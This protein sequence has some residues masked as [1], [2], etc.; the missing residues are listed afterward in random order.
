MKIHH[1]IL[2]LGACLPAIAPAQLPDEAL[3]CFKWFSTLGYPDVKD[4]K[5]AEIWTGSWSSGGGQDT[6]KA[7]TVMGF[8]TKETASEFTVSRLDLIPETLSKSMQETPAHESVKF[9]ERPFSKMIDQHLEAL[10]HP[11][12]DAFPRFRATLGQRAEV[13]ILSYVCWQ[14]G[15]LDLAAQLYEE[16]RRLPFRDYRIKN[17][18]VTMQESLEIML[19]HTAMWDAVLRCGGGRLG[20]DDWAGSGKLEPRT[21]LLEAF[22]RIARL[23]PRSFEAAEVGQYAAMLERM[24]KEDQ[25]HPVLTQEQIDQLPLEKRIAEL[26]WMLRDQNGHQWGQPGWCDVFSTKK[27]RGSKSPA[28]QL[29]DIGYPAAHAL[30]E[31]LTDERFSRSVGFHRDFHFSHTVLTIG[32]CAQ[33][34]LNHLTGQN[35]YSPASTSGY[36]SNEEKML[37]VQKAA[38]K[39]LEEYQKKGKKQML[40][41]SITAGKTSPNALVQQL[42]AEDPE[43]VEDAVLRGA[44]AA[45]DAWLLRQFIKEL[46]SLKRPAATQ[47]LL[48]IM[49]KNARLEVRLEAAG[50]LMNQKHPEALPAMVHEW[51]TLQTAEH[52]NHDDGFET[53]VEMH[54]A[55]GDVQAMRQIVG[56]WDRLRAGE[57]LNIAQKM[58]EW[59]KEGIELHPFSSVKARPLTQEAKDTG[60]G[61]LVHA[62]EDRETLDGMTGGLG[63][64]CFSS[65]RIC[66]FALWA[67]HEIDA[68]KFAFTPVAGRR[69]RDAERIAAANV[70]GQQFR[71][72]LLPLPPPP[73]A[74]LPE[75]DALKIVSVQIEP[76]KGFEGTSL[77][78]RALELRD[79]TFGPRTISSLLLS[80]ANEPTS[81]MSGLRVEALRE[82]DLT[83]VEIHLRVEPGDY[84]QKENEGWNTMHNGQIGNRNLSSSGGSRS[85]STA[86]N[87]DVW[88]SFEDEIAEGLKSPP[89]TGFILVAS[90]KAS[91]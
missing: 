4:A 85:R 88:E 75:K 44:E 83:G 11:P 68:K 67:L 22:R 81:G 62:L 7:S 72:P 69:Q 35:F 33:Q 12:K 1:L 86:G 45:S 46:G 52:H 3:Q 21:A 73:G 66:D 9:E 32:D 79:S 40:V 49:K 34:I 27:K 60:I 56:K 63:E 48:K 18:E 25:N 74:P 82:N 20:W 39:W 31:A 8:V 5:W 16:A 65:P 17:R 57:R 50:Q 24:V 41:E 29:L 77:I 87:A 26:V 13:F 23:F 42:K 90:L 53:L 55:S 43:A 91:R 80:F 89:T 61:L 2:I 30:I 59:M 15:Q 36:M 19:G 54:I 10:R 6:P 78:K 71:K 58:G 37:D 38:R 47:M 14:R 84:P 64:F 76:D 51:N 28:E 70:L